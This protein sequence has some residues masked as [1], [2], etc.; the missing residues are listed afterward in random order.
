MNWLADEIAL[1]CSLLL[2]LL[3]KAIIMGGLALWYPS[4]ED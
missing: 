2:S 1:V 3:S 4:M